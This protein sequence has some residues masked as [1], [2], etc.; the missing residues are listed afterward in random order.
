MKA[1]MKEIAESLGV[2]RATVDR[3]LHDRSRISKT[4]K[5]KVLR[6]VRELNYNPNILGKCLKLKKSFLVG[7]ITPELSVSF[8]PEIIQGIEEVL[9]KKGYGIILRS[10]S[11]RSNSGQIEKAITFLINKHIDGLIVSYPD[12]PCSLY[13][14]LKEEQTPLIFI[15]HKFEQVNVPY[16]GL[17]NVQG[18]YMATAHLIKYGYKKI[19]YVGQLLGNIGER[20]SGYKKA[21]RKHK[22]PL[23]RK[24]VNPSIENLLE[25][26]DR[27][28]SVFASTDMIAARI[29]A[30]AYEK[31][32]SLPQ[33]L[34]IVGFDDIPLASL[35][36]PALTTIAQPKKMMGKIGA[37]N[38]IKLMAGLKVKNIILQPELVIR[39]S[40][41]S[42]GQ[43]GDVGRD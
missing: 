14:R 6:K 34:A 4:T 21:L 41:P 31:G 7:V 23:D 1:T 2:S 10:L 37:D 40:V 16:V 3:A 43:N 42:Y 9:D 30:I 15:S 12:F 24:L 17:D 22:I 35:I 28:V 33:D 36:K 5:R 18:G 26:A 25:T 13:K 32:F 27:P 19:V 29:M 38:L 39:E 8:Y 20:F 11:Y